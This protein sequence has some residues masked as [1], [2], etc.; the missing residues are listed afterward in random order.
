MLLFDRLVVSSVLGV[1]GERLEGLIDIKVNG[2]G[3]QRA[4]QSTE[5]ERRVARGETH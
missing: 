3:D 2:K 1:V 4:G 5:E